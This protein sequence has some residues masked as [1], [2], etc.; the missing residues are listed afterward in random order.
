[1]KPTRPFVLTYAG[2]IFTKLLG[3]SESSIKIKVRSHGTL[4]VILHTSAFIF[5]QRLLH[6]N[7]IVQ[8]FQSSKRYKVEVTATGLEPTTT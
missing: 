5:K 8:N 1:M 7:K 2:R 6:R 3:I 4:F